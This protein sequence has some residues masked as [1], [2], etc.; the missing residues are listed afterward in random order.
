VQRRHFLR[1]GLASA[2]VLVVAGGS[3]ALVQP[4]FADGRLTDAGRRVFRS[5]GRAVLDGSLPGDAAQR[6]AALDAQLTRLDTAIAAFP[7][8]TIAEISQLLALLAIAPGRLGLAGLQPDWHDAST[9][10][11][12]A[13]LQ[14]MRH[15]SLSLRQQAYHALRDLTNAAWYAEPSSWVQIGYPGPRDL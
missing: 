12:Q 9:A 4:G 15:A 10:Q 11:V 13:A 14:G 1:L 7:P 3:I 5:V 8:A 6:E 2:A